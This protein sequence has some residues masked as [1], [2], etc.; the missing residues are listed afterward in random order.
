MLKPNFRN[1]EDI[2]EEDIDEIKF[3]THQLTKRERP[4][5]PRNIVIFPCFSEFGTEVL[6]TL[7]CIPKLMKRY[8]GKYSIAMGWHGR[9]FLYKNLVD[10]FWELD[11][12]HQWLRK[13][14]RAFHH[15]SKNL[16]RIEKKAA[17]IGRVIDSLE[18]GQPAVYPKFEACLISGC[19]GKIKVL[20]HCQMCK[21]C[22]VQY[23]CPGIFTNPLHYKKDAVWPV[24]SQEK[25]LVMAKY[26]KPNSVGI[27][28]RN[29]DAYGRNLPPIFYE[30]LIYLLE[31]MGYNP[32]WI[33]ERETIL[34]CP[35]ARITDFSIFPEAK[36]LENTLA[37]VSQ[38]K[39][40][41]QFWTASTRLAGL[42]GTPYILFESP[43]QVYGGNMTPGHEGY[44][45]FLCGKK[46][47]KK[48][49]MAHYKSVVED[50]NTALSLVKQAVSDIENGDFSDIAGL[51]QDAF[52]WKNKTGDF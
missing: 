35:F 45:M 38:L 11:E 19:G 27:T 14:C 49:V 50:H 34:P 30:R 37:L 33:G 21:K 3:H 46:D 4:L 51:V 7:Y 12:E 42:V 5:D 18:L 44:R 6:G 41:I 26:L 52:Y 10:E 22:R 15:F 48:L 39:F 40:T 20:D 29:R 13:Y 43:D 1:T 8:C 16:T 2:P 32:I 17:K 23:P 9:T 24:V 36:D 47:N 31:D 25:Q 28:A